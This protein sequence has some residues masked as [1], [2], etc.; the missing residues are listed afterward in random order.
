VHIP[1]C[2]VRCGY[3]DF[4]TY[5]ASELRGVNQVDF[6]EHLISEIVFS[7]EVL[8]KS[9]YPS[10]PL[11]T[12]FFG[13]GTP[14]L[15]DPKSIGEIISALK[16]NFGL[17]DGAEITLE[18]NPESLTRSTIS[19]FASA[20][21]N[22]ISLGVQ[23]FDPM[24]LKVLDRIHTLEKVEA[25]VQNVQGA[26]LRL[27]MDLIYG[28]PGESLASWQQTLSTTLAFAPGHVSAYSLIVEEGTALQRRIARHELA[29][30]DED[31]NADKYLMADEMFQAAG[32]QNYEVSNWGDP[33]R[34]NQA[35]WSS[36][37]WWGYGPG[38]HS[39]IA[40]TRF[41]NHKHPANYASWLTKGSPAHSMEQLSERTRLE[42]RL[43]LELRTSKGVPISLIRDLGVS[44]QKV[45]MAIAD[46]FM[47]ITPEQHLAPTLAGRLRVDGLVLSFLS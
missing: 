5:T 38:A 21:V 32:L 30:V 31:L 25:A 20:G 42:E 18:A 12:V 39:H 27:S 43:L 19:G 24:V 14:S 9:G 34:H 8:D 2:V 47:T 6:H 44:Q 26:G 13:G 11:E 3:C 41:W 45:A 29:D 37:D 4:N 7:K 10:K 22:R 17:S 35:Y 15:V 16:T 46:G 40:G 23:S 1:F 33:S 36:M 28:T